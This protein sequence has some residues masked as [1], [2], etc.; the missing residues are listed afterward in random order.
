[1]NM[2]AHQKLIQNLKVAKIM[3]ATGYKDSEIATQVGISTKDFLEIVGN[4]DYLTEIFKNAVE[5]VASEVERKFLEKMMEKLEEGDT[6]DA[7]FFMERTMPRYSRKEN[8]QVTGG[9][10]ID[11]VIRRNSSD[12]EKAE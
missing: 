10:S 9:L 4:D 3:K 11:E 12:G 6:Q 5:K 2:I 1:M 7:K 8:V